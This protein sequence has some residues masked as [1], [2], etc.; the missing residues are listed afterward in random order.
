MPHGC[1]G[2]CCRPL[3]WWL[4]LVFSPSGQE[5]P[6]LVFLWAAFHIVK[7][8]PKWPSSLL[9]PCHSK[10]ILCASRTG[11]TWEKLKCWISV[12]IYPPCTLESKSA[13]SQEY[14]LI[15]MFPGVWEKV[16]S[17]SSLSCPE[18]VHIF[19]EGGRDGGVHVTV[20]HCT[21]NHCSLVNSALTFRLIHFA[22]VFLHLLILFQLPQCLCCWSGMFGESHSIRWSD[23]KCSLVQGLF[24]I[25]IPEPHIDQPRCLQI[26]FSASRHAMIEKN[27]TLQHS[28]IAGSLFFHDHI[29]RPNSHSNCTIHSL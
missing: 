24:Y 6:L 5:K 11:I 29:R 21:W 12:P 19:W 2:H 13:F 23:S 14:Q 18:H 27:P 8:Y 25:Y 1:P 28:K 10:W 7:L 22:K 16:L 17:T 26:W 4:L 15:F 20:S 9:D 3:Y